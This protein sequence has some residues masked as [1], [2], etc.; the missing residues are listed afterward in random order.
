[1]PAGLEMAT[2][3]GGD[4]SGTVTEGRSGGSE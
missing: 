1:V 3:G 2:G 4:A